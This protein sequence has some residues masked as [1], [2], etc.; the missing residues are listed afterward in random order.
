MTRAWIRCPDL[1]SGQDLWSLL[2]SC[3]LR[4]PLSVPCVR[5]LLSLTRAERST[6]E[7]AGVT[8]GAF[9]V[10]PDMEGLVSTITPPLQPASLRRWCS[11][12]V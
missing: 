10:V 7:E 6:S 9:G 5:V 8:V 4:L 12:R 3:P 2:A 1:S 11:P